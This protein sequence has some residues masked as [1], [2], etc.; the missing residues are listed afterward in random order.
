LVTVPP[1]P[2]VLSDILISSPLISG[3]TEGGAPASLGG[4]GM[5]QDQELEMVKTE[6]EKTKKVRLS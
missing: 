4:F 1:G 2:H 5:E 6:N 3:G